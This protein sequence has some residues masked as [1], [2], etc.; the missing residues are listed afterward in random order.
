VCSS[1]LNRAVLSVTNDTSS[2]FGAV[3]SVMVSEIVAEVMDDPSLTLEAFD[4]GDSSKIYPLNVRDNLRSKLDYVVEFDITTG[5]RRAVN[6][7][8]DEPRGF[9]LS[10]VE[11][12]S[13][14]RSGADP[15]LPDFYYRQLNFLGFGN[16]DPELRPVLKI[17]YSVVD[18]LNGGGK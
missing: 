6:R 2:S 13:V 14:F 1:D 15:T 7:V 16:A 10:G 11:D 9:L 17:W 5:I 3:F 4:L 12:R 18:E 8:Y